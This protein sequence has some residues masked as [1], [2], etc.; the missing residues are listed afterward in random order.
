MNFFNFHTHT[1]RCGHA[2]GEDEEYV[3][4]AIRE[5]FHSLGF[6]DH[7]ML[8]GIRDVTMRGSVEID[9]PDYLMSIGQLKEKYQSKIDIH[10]GFESEYYPEF[11]GYY[12]ELLTTKK[13]EYL[14]LGQHFPYIDGKFPHYK[15]VE[16]YVSDLIRGMD[17]GLFAYVAHP[18]MLTY[19]YKEEDEKMKN[20]ILKIIEAA[21]RNDIPLELNLGK[22]VRN[23]VN[24]E[25]DIFKDIPFPYDYFWD[26]VGKNHIK[27]VIGLDAHKP[28]EL[29]SKIYKYG[30]SYAK[31][32]HLDVMNEEDF[33]KRIK[34]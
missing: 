12:K 10:I 28:Q 6:S 22:I 30:L 2:F 16:D 20:Q 13:I 21:K 15:E 4:N 24:G 29:S 32:H 26:L 25:I 34:S 18:D 19:F 31:T 9:L 14:I 17:S 27:V 3:K 7:I 23:Y 8:P 5:G 1:T 11:D 33:L